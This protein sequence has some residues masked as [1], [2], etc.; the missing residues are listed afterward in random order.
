MLSRRKYKKKLIK[1]AELKYSD[2][3]QATYDY[4]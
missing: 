3:T 1:K 2:E 4:K